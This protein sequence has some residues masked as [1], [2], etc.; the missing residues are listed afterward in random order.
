MSSITLWK[1]REQK[2]VDPLLF[3]DIAEAMAKQLGNQDKRKNKGTQLRRFFDEIV[4]LNDTAKSNGVGMEL[5]LPNLHMIIA[6]A[7]YAEGRRLV[8][9]DFVALIRDGIGQVET[10]ED[11][12]V[13]TS[14]FESL[15]AFYKLHGPN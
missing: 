15:M 12:K 4:R 11:L 3:S 9:P 5:I 14:F 7:A 2:I 10:K 13:F 8:T 1:D 6:K